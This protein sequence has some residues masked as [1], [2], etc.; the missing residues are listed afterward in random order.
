[1]HSQPEPLAEALEFCR[2]RSLTPILLG[3]LFDSQC[4]RSDSYAVYRLARK[5]QD[6][7]GAIILRSNHQALLEMLAR[8]EAIPL[9]KDLARTVKDF[10]E[11][12][13]CIREVGSWLET[14]PYLVCLKDKLGQEYRVAHAEIPD[15]IQPPSDYNTLWMLHK[16]NQ[17]ERE[18]LLWGKPYTVPDRERFWWLHPSSREWI[19]VAGHYHKVFQGNM[20]LIL[21]G[22]C[23]GK[24]RSWKD[25]RLPVLML[26]EV[27]SQTLV[28]FDVAGV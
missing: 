7:L 15:S 20:S 26:Y 2:I 24:S 21:D 23:G 6:S 5:A 19:G 25:R 22:G 11:N 17:K 8:R 16:P 14:F 9:K 10:V 27:N 4:S 3:D 13:V 1:M 18:L 28:P 12:G